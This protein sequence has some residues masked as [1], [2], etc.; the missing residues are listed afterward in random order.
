MSLADDIQRAFRLIGQLQ[1]ALGGKTIRGGTDTVV[2]DGSSYQSA[3]L[4]VPHDLGVVP[5][6][7]ELTSHTT[8][9]G[10][11]R[12]GKDASKIQV[13]GYYTPGTTLSASSH[14]FDWEVRG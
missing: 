6:T 7:V 13:R 1:G 8:L 9:I 5:E 14:D 4:D 12:V 11:A 2:F 10:F 3:I